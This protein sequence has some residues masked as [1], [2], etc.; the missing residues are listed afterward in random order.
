MPVVFNVNKQSLTISKENSSVDNQDGSANA[1]V[2]PISR[3]TSYFNKAQDHINTVHNAVYAYAVDTIASAI[4]R[5]GHMTD[6][7]RAHDHGD[8]DFA[9]VSKYIMG[10]V[11]CAMIGMS[12]AMFSLIGIHHHGILQYL[13]HSL[14]TVNTPFVILFQ[15][16][17]LGIF[18]NVG[19]FTVMKVTN[20]AR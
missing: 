11:T 19:A 3:V 5:F 18:L 10:V 17:V 15:M 4:A 8:N 7:K 20:S 16:T 2:T 13:K 9:R 14:T 1:D 12:I 6:N